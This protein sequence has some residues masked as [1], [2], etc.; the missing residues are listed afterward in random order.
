MF[1]GENGGANALVQYIDSLNPETIA[2]L[3]APTSEVRQAMEAS[4]SSLLG[5][6]PPQNFGVTITTN[7]EN[8]GHLLASAMMN[9]YFL[10]S[11][12]QRMAIDQSFA[13]LTAGTSDEKD[14]G[15]D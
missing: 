14:S 8:L 5:G 2:R 1:A 12:Q 11:A 15:N 3:S 7:R 6:L 13:T 9:G 4:L 10:H